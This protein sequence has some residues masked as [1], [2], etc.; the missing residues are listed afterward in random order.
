MRSIEGAGGECKLGRQGREGGR[1]AG[2]WL[3]AAGPSAASA[4]ALCASLTYFQYHW[5]INTEA[6]E[7]KRNEMYEMAATHTHTHI[8]T[9]IESPTHTQREWKRQRGRA[10]RIQGHFG[11]RQWGEKKAKAKTRGLRC[12]CLECECVW[13]V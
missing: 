5:S 1:E 11:A 3:W 6:N 2:G 7:S 9:Y 10:A 12:V 13:L 4:G 8:D